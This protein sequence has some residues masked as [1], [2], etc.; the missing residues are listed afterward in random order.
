MLSMPRYNQFQLQDAISNSLSYAEALRYL[1]LCEAGGNHETIKRY[2]I[3]W[4]ISTSH[5]LSRTEIAKRHIFR[6][7][8]PLETVLMEHSTYS[9]SALKARLFKE[10]LKK[11]ICELCGQGEIW[12]G[13]RMALI[14]DH[15][16]GIR[17]DARLMNLRI[18]CPNCNATLDTHCGKRSQ[19]HCPICGRQMSLGRKYCSMTCYKTVLGKTPKPALRK[20]NR[21]PYRQLLEQVEKFG[22]TATGRK[23]GVSDNAVRKWLKIYQKYK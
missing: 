9:R 19:S 18:V 20:A 3:K 13:K 5:F 16:N 22:F 10:G 14:L 4:N 21:P 17:D 11:P 7:A 1:K 8:V 6:P 12:R 23:Y 15:V 2:C